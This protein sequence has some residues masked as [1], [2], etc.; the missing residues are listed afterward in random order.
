MIF[1]VTPDHIM[2]LDDTDLR[3]LVGRLAEQE[4]R[5]S[6]F[7]AAAVTYGGEQDAPDGGID[8]RVDLPAGDIDG[9]VGRG[10]AG[11]Q[12]K[13]Q[14]MPS[15][16]I[17]KEMRPKGVLRPAIIDL[18]AAG[19]AY[20]IVSS[21]GSVTDLA[22]RER[23]AAM[24]Q[25]VQDLELGE[26]L[27]LDFYDRRRLATWVNEHPGLSAW[28]R[29]RVG[30]LL[31]GW[32]GF[33]D[34]SSSPVLIDE[35]YLADDHLRLNGAALGKDEGVGVV[36]GLAKLREI[37]VLPAGAV[38]LV[39]LSG[40]GKTRLVQALFDDRLGSQALD[41]ALAVYTD[42]ADNPDPVPLELLGR[43]EHLASP[44]VLIVDNCGIELHRKL[45]AR[46]Q[47]SGAPVS[48]V[49]VEYD[50]S[51]DAPEHTDV[52]R[53]EPA[54]ARTI[55][56]LLKR[57]YPKLSGPE[58]ETIARFSEG[59]FRIALA[60]AETARAGESLAN[61][62]DGDL[63]RRLFRQRNTDD[64]AL[65]RAAMACSLVYSFDGETLDGTSGELFH[66]ASLA[67][68]APRDLYARVSE[69]H[70]RQLVQKR[71]RWRALL[72]HAIAH[73]LARQ[74]LQDI[75]LPEIILQFTDLAPERLQ[76]SFSRRIGFL[77]DSSEAQAIVRAWLGPGGPLA[78]V[79][80]LTERGLMLLSNVAPVDPEAVLAS[81]ERAAQDNSDFFDIDV[82][83][84]R[85]IVSLLRS[86]AYDPD[87]FER[88]MILMAG[89]VPDGEK[90]NN[91]GDAENV[92][93]SMFTIYLS[94]T[95]AP[96]EARAA[97]IRKLARSDLVRDQKLALG[98]L[99]S[100]L[101][102]SSFMSAQGFEF[103]ARKRDYGF[104][105]RQRSDV[106]G[107]FGAMFPLCRDLAGLPNF[108]NT[109]RRKVASRFAELVLE[110]GFTDDLIALAHDFETDGGWPEG[111]AGV[112]R[113]LRRLK[114]GTRNEEIT[115]LEVLADLLKPASLAER[116]AAYVLPQ[117]WSALDIA[118]LDLQDDT[119]H[120]RA[121]D[122]VAEICTAIG[123]ELAADFD[124][125]V[126]HLPMLVGARSYMVVTVMNVVGRES[127]DIGAA[128]KAICEAWFPSKT[129]AYSLPA[130]FLSG[131]AQQDSEA[132]ETILDE[133][134]ADPS[135]K[136][137][138]VH[139]QASAG[140]TDRGI[141]RL[142][143]AVS[144]P[145][146]ASSTFENLAYRI[147]WDAR[148]ANDLASIILALAKREDGNSVASFILHGYIEDRK[149]AGVPLDAELKEAGRTLFAACKLER[150]ETDEKPGNRLAPIVRF[151]LEPGKDDAIVRDFCSRF[152]DAVL[153]YAIYS[154]DYGDLMAELGAKFPRA[155]LDIL[156][157]GTWDDDEGMPAVGKARGHRLAPTRAIEDEVAVAWAREK[158]VPRFTAL[159]HLIA[160]W[161]KAGQPEVVHPDFDDSVQDIVWKD[162]ALR[163]MR[164]APEPEP[165]L[166][167]YLSRFRPGGWSGSL[168]Q[169]LASRMPLLNQLKSDSDPKVV[170]WA[171]GA[172][173]R[174][175]EEIENIRQWEAGRDRDRDERFEW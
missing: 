93:Y 92:F 101:K 123:S 32:Q 48:L 35:D 15:K 82:T 113:A 75:P 50:I 62:N 118:E 38:R 153:S 164:D 79:G 170:I 61:L 106:E 9:F 109:I 1:D 116:I 108:R 46:M 132:V 147:D 43:I 56:D 76:I 105:P 110:S 169:I 136:P 133:A 151:C 69:L 160:L 81:F 44:C 25:A 3:L 152:A 107:W 51:D 158:P 128:W 7:S 40:V 60:L 20:V 165:I 5:R 11:F 131:A 29:E 121:R 80:A 17:V 175:E 74:A 154:D 8:V 149:R 94:G 102:L 119:A 68:Q 127:P 66:L 95:H 4:V 115:K 129:G 84:Q 30:L 63:F 73:R 130:L 54:S 16:A 37:L 157:E 12:V 150:T 47:L 77:H 71:A 171:K 120:S 114:G 10:Q 103:G 168:A 64:P 14:D 125:L 85:K 137:M 98:S 122:R 124:T 19:G 146:V 83:R 111:W 172:I 161:S 96:P 67:G 117:G 49:T 59:N 41:P 173:P 155:I 23:R 99:S 138:L 2:R 88:A 55:E 26:H 156:V 70:R 6:G 18:A 97:L 89:F 57:R 28:V 148:S 33:G 144:M 126:E 78:A 174:L 163:L 42:L 22:L 143:E 34:W 91:L 52:I 159:A 53:L 36:E 21:K 141:E 65:Y 134:L 145:D 39:G 100:A 72:P 24:R 86:I 142:L 135:F 27:R 166:E 139:L 167:I 45:V 90:T 162:T 87:L 104:Q 58:F 13:A 31:S 140:L 112:Q